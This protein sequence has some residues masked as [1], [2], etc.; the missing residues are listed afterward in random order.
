MSTQRSKGTVRINQFGKRSAPGARPSN[1]TITHLTGGPNNDQTKINS[2]H[3]YDH[4]IGPSS[5]TRK[6]KGVAHT[7]K[8]QTS[9][10]YTY[11]G[12]NGKAA[13]TANQ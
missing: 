7:G 11:I 6:N 1:G 4:G 8:S 10:K 5:Y 13:G 12:S 2:A 9:M 3:F